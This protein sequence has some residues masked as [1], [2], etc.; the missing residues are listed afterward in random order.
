LQLCLLVSSLQERQTF[1]L[2]YFSDTTDSNP[3]QNLLNLMEC[4]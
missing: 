4:F 1:F 2:K 3:S